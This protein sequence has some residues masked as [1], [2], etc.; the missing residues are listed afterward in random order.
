VREVVSARHFKADL[1]LGLGTVAFDYM[2]R[3]SGNV[4][5]G[6]WAPLSVQ[7]VEQVVVTP[8]SQAMQAV[9]HCFISLGLN[10]L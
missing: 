7:D 6:Q 2:A 10:G 3:Q 8:R 9:T 5:G 4:A 1:R